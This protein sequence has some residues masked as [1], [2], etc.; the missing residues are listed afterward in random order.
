MVITLLMQI[1]VSV[2]IPNRLIFA[3]LVAADQALYDRRSAG[4]NR[5]VMAESH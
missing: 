4:R 1:G 3:P 2:V 5:L